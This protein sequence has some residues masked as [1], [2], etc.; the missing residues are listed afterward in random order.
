MPVFNRKNLAPAT[1]KG[2]KVWQPV[3]VKMFTWPFITYALLSTLGVY[4]V[5]L[6]SIVAANTFIGLPATS[7]VYYNNEQALYYAFLTSGPKFLVIIVAVGFLIKDIASGAKNRVKTKFLP[8]VLVIFAVILFSNTINSAQNETIKETQTDN[9]SSWTQ[10]QY[11]L[12]FD[13]TQNALV[14]V[15]ED[16]QYIFIE[17][18]GDKVVMKTND[19]TDKLTLKQVSPKE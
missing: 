1:A 12:D 7:E 11:G 6:L 10:N 17:E 15:D 18:N 2:G 8:N 9:F 3:T 14:P 19:K 16:S 13:E 4:L 5:S